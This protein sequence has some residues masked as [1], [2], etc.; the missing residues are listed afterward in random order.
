MKT[1]PLVQA[2]GLGLSITLGIIGAMPEVGR[3]Q[4]RQFNIL[5]EA[6]STPNF[7]QLIEHSEEQ[8]SQRIA[9]LFA[10]DPSLR[11]V[12]VTILANRDGAVVPILR[13]NISREDWQDSRQIA[14]WT[15]YFSSAQ[16]LLSYQPLESQSAPPREPSLST[17]FPTTQEQI[18]LQDELD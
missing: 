6:G 18:E 13:T 14:P 11:R 2:L 16:V 7:W 10:S 9:D 17:E 12:Q 5:I 4:L 3:A 8:A 15:Q 1:S